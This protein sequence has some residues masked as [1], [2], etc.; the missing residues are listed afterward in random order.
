MD[1]TRLFVDMDGTLA[2]FK[3]A[4]LEELYRPGYFA[5][6]EPQQSVVDAIRLVCQS[7]PDI[8]VYILSAAL[9][10]SKTAVAE[11]NLW[12]NQ[13]LPELE[14][15]HRIF[16]PC[17]KEKAAYVPN[18]VGKNDF[19][20]DD[21][22]ANLI[23][24]SQHGGK[25]IKLLNGINHTRGSWLGSQ[26]RYDKDPAQLALNIIQILDRASL[27]RDEK[28]MPNLEK[29]SDAMEQAGYEPVN[30]DTSS[31]E[32]VLWRDQ[33]SGKI[34]GPDG[35]DSVKGFLA[36]VGR[37]M[38][39]G[40]EIIQ[41][42]DAADK[43]FVLGESDKSP[44]RFVTWRQFSRGSKTFYE[45]GHYFQEKLAAQRDLLQR[46]LE[47]VDDEAQVVQASVP[48]ITEKSENIHVDGHEGTWYTISREAI[49][50]VDYFLLE[51]EQYGDEV[52]SVIVND[53]GQVICEDIWNG[54]D[55][56]A[57]FLPESM[58]SAEQNSFIRDMKSPRPMSENEKKIYS[59]LI[60]LQA[61]RAIDAHEGEYGAD[62]FRAFPGSFDFEPEL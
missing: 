48:R 4:E 41:T 40:Y 14:K 38:N 18:G 34:L 56:L 19:L 44:E 32:L 62:G 61:A 17:G 35:T 60:D 27:V 43:T 58:S 37:R 39:A 8:E 13:N 49:N 24:W 50:G 28:P 54:F 21:Y 6:L 53:K 51:H 1:K 9:S 11:K 52:A 22:T 33:Q 7:H 10:D 26:L 46:G 20:L 36:K 15:S 45:C 57:D 23:D 5:D 2:R 3:A 55:D 31:S 59:T 30:A 25:G 42:V 47:A 12:L 16:L 29:Y